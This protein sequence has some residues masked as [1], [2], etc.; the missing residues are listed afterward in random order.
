MED[1][2]HRLLL[3]KEL[4]DALKLLVGK[5]S[6]LFDIFDL[7]FFVS[8]TATLAAVVLFSLT[9]GADF[10]TILGLKLWWILAI[11]GSYILG[12]ASFTLGRWLR[13]VISYFF[14]N[15]KSRIVDFDSKFIE[16]I[17]AHGLLQDEPIK[18]YL[19]GDAKKMSE[20]RLY[21]RL[22]ADLRHND[23]GSSSLALLNRYW[24]LSATYDGLT[25][26]LLSWCVLSSLSATGI[27]GTSSML[28]SWVSGLTSLFLII[29]SIST[30]R[31]ASRYEHYQ[32]EELVA[33]IAS[34][35]RQTPS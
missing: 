20:W 32:I 25:I 22:W 10:S 9:L 13:Q 28:P 12:L 27:L 8:G 21:I 2:L 15:R 3:M 24:M 14:R 16:I 34:L 1:D 17:E 11:L 6:E 31:E 7:S 33:T 29:L 4:G 23:S 5:I 30:L 26:S 18:S 19:E 35:N